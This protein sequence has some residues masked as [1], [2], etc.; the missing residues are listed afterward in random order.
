MNSS[1]ELIIRKPI[2]I[3]ILVSN[4]LLSFKIKGTGTK[5]E[6]IEFSGDP[7]IHLSFKFVT[8]SDISNSKTPPFIISSCDK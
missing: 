2:S 4:I 6:G 8:V 7:L 5:L 1:L 3:E